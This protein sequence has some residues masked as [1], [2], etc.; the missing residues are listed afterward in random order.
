[1][2]LLSPMEV[3]ECFRVAMDKGQPPKEIEREVSLSMTGIKRFLSLIDGLHKDIKRKK[4]VDWDGKNFISFSSAVELTKISDFDDQ[5]V[6]AKSIL[7]DKLNSKEVRYVAQLRKRAQ[8]SMEECIKE[9][10]GMRPTIERRYVFIGS[11]T[12]TNLRHALSRL[13]QSK[14]DMILHVCLDK[15]NLE[16]ATGRLGEQFF[17]LVGDD[18][19]ND[20]MNAIGKESIEGKIQFQI[21]QSPDIS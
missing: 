2:R 6:V 19:F 12:D 1:M 7:K 10:V 13:T 9:I 18:F 5:L 11:I 14:R 20:S 4:W 15:I 17:T 8:K 16:G 3:A 21:A